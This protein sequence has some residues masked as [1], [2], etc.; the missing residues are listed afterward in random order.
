VSERPRLFGAFRKKTYT[1]RQFFTEAGVVRSHRRVIRG[2]WT[3]DTIDPAFREAIMV[4]VA[5]VNG[6][7]YCS[8]AHHEWALH[9]GL[10]ANQLAQIEGMDPAHFDRKKW[11]A[12]EYARALAAED[13]GPVSPQLQ[14][15]MH[16]AY[17]A[18]E[19]RDIEIVARVMTFSN[20]SANTLDALASRLKGAPAEGRRLLDELVI[21]FL[22]LLV[23]PVVIARMAMWKRASPFTL[24]REFRRF[25][26]GLEAETAA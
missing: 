6:C 23:F 1:L 20:L 14:R 26:R 19:I 16:A 22:V 18:D 13:F 24:L 3:M 15:E 17:T 2:V 10:P 25:S 5:R 9:V 21:S 7:R 11:L 4:A 12:I 8:F